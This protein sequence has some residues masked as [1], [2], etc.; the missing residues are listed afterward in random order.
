MFALGE[1]KRI[2]YGKCKCLDQCFT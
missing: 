2:N 1:L